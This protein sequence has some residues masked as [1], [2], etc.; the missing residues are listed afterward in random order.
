MGSDRV[1]A[2]SIADFSAEKRV[3]AERE[4]VGESVERVE[5]RE[6]SA[7]VKAD[8][9][10]ILDIEQYSFEEFVFRRGGN[11]GKGESSQGKR[12][13]H[14]VKSGAAGGFRRSFFPLTATRFSDTRRKRRKTKKSSYPSEKKNHIKEKNTKGCRGGFFVRERRGRVGVF[15]CLEGVRGSPEK[16]F[17]KN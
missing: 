12:K 17:K 15:L 8:C 3:G 7:W 6:G 5:Y 13:N 4:K 14:C 2:G 10:L 11:I 9:F 16:F 1:A